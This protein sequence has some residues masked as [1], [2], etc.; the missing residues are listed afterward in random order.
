MVVIDYLWGGNMNIDTFNRM[1]D[2]TILINVVTGSTDTKDNWL[3]D[4]RGTDKDERGTLAEWIKTL[5]IA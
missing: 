1:S 3:A 5:E 2:E 4:Y